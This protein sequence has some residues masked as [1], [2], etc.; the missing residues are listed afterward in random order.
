MTTIQ[1][2]D[3]LSSRFV[4]GIPYRGGARY[5]WVDRLGR[6][7]IEP[8]FAYADRFSEGLAIAAEKKGRF[9]YVDRDG[10]FAIPAEYC[11]AARFRENLARVEIGRTKSRLGRF[12]LIDRLGNIVVPVAFED[13]SWFSG[14]LCAV[15]VDGKWGYINT[16]GEMVIKVSGVNYFS[17]SATTLEFPTGDNYPLGKAAVAT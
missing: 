6:V 5:G 16:S 11:G 17:L 9:G 12:G 14:G 13:A 3:V 10:Q 8:R 4:I 15:R 7:V 2:A 1:D